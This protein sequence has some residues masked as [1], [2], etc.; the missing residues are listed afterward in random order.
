[1]QGHDVG[2]IDSF[3]LQGRVNDR[4]GQAI[5]TAGCLFWMLDVDL[6]AVHAARRPRIVSI[7]MLA[8]SY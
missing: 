5:F 2:S 1:M 4:D 8:T 3:D 6:S 7:S